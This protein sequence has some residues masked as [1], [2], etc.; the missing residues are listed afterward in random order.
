MKDFH[1]S[2][3]KEV[4]EHTR[5]RTH[6]QIRD[7]NLPAEHSGYVF[8]CVFVAVGAILRMPRNTNSCY[9]LSVRLLHTDA[10]PSD[11]SD[12]VS[13]REQTLYL[14]VFK[15]KKVSSSNW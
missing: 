5:T 8:V 7:L 15:K 10:P 13:R 4:P 2:S 12:P 9:V 6:T 14:S 11:S 3:V 1:F